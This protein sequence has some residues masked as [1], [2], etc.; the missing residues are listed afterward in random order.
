MK[1]MKKI[2]CLIAVVCCLVL[3][4]CS[5]SESAEEQVFVPTPEC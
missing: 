4:G 2:F 1:N 3:A 5:G